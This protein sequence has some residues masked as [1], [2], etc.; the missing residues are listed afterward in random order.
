MFTCCGRCHPHSRHARR[1]QLYALDRLTGRVVFP[2]TAQEGFALGQLDAPIEPE[3]SAVVEDQLILVAGDQT[4]V[5]PS[6][7]SR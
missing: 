7:T 2:E 3:H 1:C 5:I 4:L 6:A